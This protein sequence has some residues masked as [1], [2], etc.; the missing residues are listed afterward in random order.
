MN[1][2]KNASIVRKISFI[3]VVSIV[4]LIAVGIV[5]INNSNSG[6]DSLVNVDKKIKRVNELKEVRENLENIQRYYASL[7]AG[8]S[9][10]EGTIIATEANIKFINEFIEKKQ[11]LFKKNEKKLFNDFIIEWKKAQPSLV[12]IKP[13][14]EDEDDDV[15]RE[16]IEDEWIVTYFNAVKKINNL[17]E[18]INKEAAKDI[19]S[20]K[21]SL[22]KNLNIIYIALILVIVGV[23]FISIFISRS[24]TK[25]LKYIS[26]AL[27][28][29][30]GND[31]EMRLNINTND[32]IG[33]IAKSFDAFFEHLSEVFDIAKKSSLKNT[34]VAKKSSQITITINQKVKDE[35]V[36]VKQSSQK[37]EEV[38]NS[39]KNSLEIAESSNKDITEANKKLNATKNDILSLVGDIN[40]ASHV[41]NELAL[42]L[43]NLSNDTQQVKNVLIV[44]A[45]IADQTNLL[46]LNAAI[47]AARAG[48]HGR[49]FAV[50][51]DEV[52]NLAE[53]TQKSLVEIDSTISVIVQAIVE[54][55]EDMSKNSNSINE[56][57]H[58]SNNI[59]HKI[60]EVVDIMESTNDISL[61]SL[62]DF[63]TMSEVTTQLIDEIKKVSDISD[64]NVKSI[65]EVVYFMDELDKSS[66]ELNENLMKFKTS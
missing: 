28:S 59:E 50:V 45:E 20:Q 61:K 32:E 60:S 35:Q 48:E 58:K 41:E 47:E 24:I 38:Q 9:A 49:G 46:A 63:K 11:Q 57:S 12:K 7:L 66:Q 39:L 43:S 22:S 29:N 44:I 40:D 13:A 53:R 31:L 2:I 16:I 10:Y 23:L 54:A 3:I 33:V 19:V 51:A 21:A 30:N 42:K 65:D 64:E 4:G 55:S 1:L 5:G 25:P 14:I 27:K 56:L 8:F 52:R 6:Y 37:G 15:I 26:R 62:K 36:L 18:H 17:Y 34:E